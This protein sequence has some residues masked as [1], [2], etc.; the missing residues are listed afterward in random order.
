VTAPV[1]PLVAA[2]S[3]VLAAWAACRAAAVRSLEAR[4]AGGPREA[5]GGKDLFTAA[6]RAA[7]SLRTDRRR[8]RAVE[9]Q[10]PE[11]LALQAAALR[12]GHS[13]AGSLGAVASEAGEPLGQELARCA[14][15]LDL[16]MPLEQALL[17]LGRRCGPPA[18]PWVAALLA[19]STTGGDLTRALESLAGRAR[20]RAQLRSELRALTAQ[21]RL[22]GTVVAVAPAG[23][24]A[25]MTLAS[26]DEAAALYGTATGRAVLLTGTV[27]D[28]A[29]LLWIRR[30]VR[31]TL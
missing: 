12:A 27:L 16:G 9:Q 6:R 25:L 7:R 26:R 13:I 21:G 14:G 3:A 10:V 23:F 15:E 30:I 24:L 28:V 5:R 31:I 4:L 20:A 2:S 1:A 11:V 17:A 22:S 8:T 19:G 29:G 18:G